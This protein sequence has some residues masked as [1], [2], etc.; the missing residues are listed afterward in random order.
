MTNEQPSTNNEPLTVANEQPAPDLD[1]LRSE[2]DALR[3]ALRFRDAR[4]SLTAALT[5]AGARSP[6][7][8][9]AYAAQG[10]QYVD[11]GNL[12]NGEALVADLTRSFPEQ[13]GSVQPAGIDAGTAARPPELTR[14]ALA[15][16]SPAEIARLDW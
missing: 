7:L 5:A 14:E 11:G 1:G 4:D 6:A 8:L 9:I 15:R 10:L 3:N 13:F 2:I 16:M 12:S